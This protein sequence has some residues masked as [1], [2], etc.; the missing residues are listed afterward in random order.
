M[1]RFSLLENRMAEPKTRVTAASVKD[2]LDSIKDAG[3][4]EDC[5]TIAEIMR[6]ATKA[7]PKMWGSNIVGFGVYQYTYANGKKADWM[8]TAF[9]P[10]KQNITIYIMDGLEKH[11][12]LLAKLG[13]YS[14]GKSCLH[15]KRLSDV[16]LPT[17]KRLVHTSV[18]QRAASGLDSRRESE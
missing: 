7:E 12:E 8:L 4:R 10:R 9:S 13:P 2:F 16:H 11:E 15:I 17:L 3:V 14:C 1:L 18:K 6:S 5:R